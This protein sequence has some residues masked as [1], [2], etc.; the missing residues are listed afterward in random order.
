VKE[1]GNRKK[2]KKLL[3]LLQDFVDGKSVQCRNNVDK[4]WRDTDE[5]YGLLSGFY[6]YRLRPCDFDSTVGFWSRHYKDTDN[7]TVTE[8]RVIFENVHEYDKIEWPKHNYTERPH[9]SRG[10]KE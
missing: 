8:G 4:R 10:K 7:G 5:M 2:W 1:R 6:E 3:P 9:F